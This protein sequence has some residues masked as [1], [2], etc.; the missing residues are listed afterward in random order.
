MTS[1]NPV[2]TV[3][4]RSPRCCGCTM[5][6]PRRARCSGASS[7]CSRGRHPRRGSGASTPLSAQLSG[8]QQ[9]RVM[10]AMAIAC[11]PQLLIADEPTTALDVTIQK[12]ILDLIARLK[13]EHAMTRAVHHARPARGRRDRRRRR[14]DAERRDSRAGAPSRR[15]ST[16]RSDPYTQALLACR[17]S[18]DRRPARLPVVADFMTGRASG[19]HAVDAMRRPRAAR[20]RRRRA[21]RRAA[22]E[23]LLLATKGCSAARVPGGPATCRSRCRRGKTLGLVGESGSGKTTVGL[24]LMRL[25]EA[26]TGE[27]LFEGRDLLTLSARE[28]MAYRRRH[29]DRLPESVRVAEPALHG[30]A[31][32]A[33][34]D[35]HPS[36]RGRRRGAR[37]RRDSSC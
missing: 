3:G 20:R 32:P 35:A 14:R 19:A 9:Q 22:V 23:E 6:L 24:T 25:H 27:V 1:L 7:R 2:F 15:S 17:P 34:A 30:R 29:A 10:I 8:G 37:R 33:R 21:R 28:L 18:L 12:Q 31:D 36:H 26:T 5:G 11:E 13:R 16:A 4:S